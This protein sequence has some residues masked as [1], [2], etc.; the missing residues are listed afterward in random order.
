MN[1]MKNRAIE[2]LQDRRGKL[3]RTGLM[4]LVW[5]TFFMTM[6][7]YVTIHEKKLADIPEPYVYLTLVLCGTYTARRFLDDKFGV[8]PKNTNPKA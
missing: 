4:F 2:L 3:S 8:T 1:N 6:V 7:G 5:M